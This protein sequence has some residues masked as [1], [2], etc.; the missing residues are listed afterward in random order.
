MVQGYHQWISLEETPEA[1]SILWAHLES[2][3]GRT[4]AHRHGQGKEEVGNE[5]ERQYTL[6]KEYDLSPDVSVSNVCSPSAL[7]VL[8]ENDNRRYMSGPIFQH[9]L[10]KDLD[11]IWRLEPETKHLCTFQS[12]WRQVE[13]QSVEWV[14]RDPFRYMRDNK[15][16]YAWF[17]T[18]SEYRT[19]VMSLMM[20]TNSE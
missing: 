11:F 6:C 3:L 5:D 20:T 19:T 10:L 1:K 2:R 15:K 14:E 13:G 16:K 9:P 12:H 8:T 7:K 4:L 17:M 18:M